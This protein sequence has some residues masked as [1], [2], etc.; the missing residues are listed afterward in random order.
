MLQY[1]YIYI[2]KKRLKELKS[3]MNSRKKQA[4]Y[5]NGEPNL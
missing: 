5:W 2:L 1:I 4:I 3:I